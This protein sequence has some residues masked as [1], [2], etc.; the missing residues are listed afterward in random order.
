M[1]ATFNVWGK[2]HFK[3]SQCLIFLYKAFI[4]WQPMFTVTG[5]TQA[6]A[7]LYSFTRQRLD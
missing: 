5:F 7:T 3:Y 6:D 4:H 2:A 1:A